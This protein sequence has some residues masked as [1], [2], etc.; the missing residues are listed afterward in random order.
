MDP[1]DLAYRRTMARFNI[2][3]DEALAKLRQVGA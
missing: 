1:E 2:P 3:N